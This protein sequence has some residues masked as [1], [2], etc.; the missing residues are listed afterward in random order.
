M[1]CSNCV[2]TNITCPGSSGASTSSS[3]VTRP[4]PLDRRPH[5]NDERYEQILERLTALEKAVAASTNSRDDTRTITPTSPHPTDITVAALEGASS[6]GQQAIYAT[7]MLEHDSIAGRSPEVHDDIAA[8]RSLVK[9][10]QPQDHSLHSKQHSSHVNNH[11]EVPPA[12]FSIKILQAIEGNARHDTIRHI[13]EWHCRLTASGATSSLTAILRMADY[14]EFEELSRKIY[15]PIEQ[16]SSAELNLFYALLCAAL[17]GL[18]YR[19]PPGISTEEFSLYHDMSKEKLRLSTES[20]EVN[21]I[22]SYEHTL[23]LC[24]AAAQAQTQGDLAH[25]WKLS[26]IAARHCLALGYHRQE[27]VVAL[28]SPKSH[29]VHRLF[30]SVYFLDRSLVL[31]LGRAPTIP[32]YDIDTEPTPISE[33]PGK[34]PWDQGHGLF[35]DLSRI[36]AQ[37]YE[38]LYSPASCRLSIVDRK[39][40][41]D[42]V[43]QQLLQ[44]HARWTALDS[45]SAYNTAAFDA[46]FVPV[47]VVYYTILTILYRAETRS[48]T[49]YSVSPKCYDAA[50]K[51]LE[52]GIN[53]FSNHARADPS[54][55]ALY[56]VW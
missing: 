1:P 42:R 50:R 14:D 43:S 6:F 23:I 13:N 18:Q 55:I 36:Q 37:I 5:G 7:H 32:E 40:T 44:W 25:Q 49:A 8:L 39:A 24:I 46:L 56:A 20:Y 10:A 3:A 21:I 16:I 19:R 29:R 12:A 15:F 9:L 34:R 35:I 54:M 52:A 53:V 33:D 11:S 41:V 4:R 17:Y 27:L 22:P 48:K 28:P 47:D 51:G 45:S 38:T 26:T 30:W 31:T 2:T